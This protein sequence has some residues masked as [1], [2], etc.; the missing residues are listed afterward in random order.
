[1]RTL[2]LAFTFIVANISILAADGGLTRELLKS[3]PWINNDP[4]GNSMFSSKMVFHENGQVE[5]GCTNLGEPSQ[6]A[7]EFNVAGNTIVMRR[8]SQD[9]ERIRT[10]EYSSNGEEGQLKETSKTSIEFK[11]GDI[12]VAGIKVWLEDGANYSAIRMVRDLLGANSA[13]E[14]SLLKVFNRLLYD[15]D[16]YKKIDE[17]INYQSNIS[18]PL[19]KARKMFQQKPDLSS[20][21]IAELNREILQGFFQIQLVNP[22]YN[23]WYS[24][25]HLTREP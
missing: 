21:K 5:A 10:F 8:K 4:C 16:L 6:F 15:R 22:K 3:H 17:G 14:E 9:G 13:T 25:D 24:Q 2:S 11:I 18:E 1:M 23:V 20:E 12:G 19:K 7:D